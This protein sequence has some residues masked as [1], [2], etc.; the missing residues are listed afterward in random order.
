MPVDSFVEF[1]EVT[2]T[3]EEAPERPS[4]R[5]EQ[6]KKNL[7]KRMS[8]S[9]GKWDTNHPR[10]RLLEALF[11]FSRYKPRQMAE[12]DRYKGLY[13]HV[14]KAQKAVRPRPSRAFVSYFVLL[15]LKKL[16]LAP[17]PQ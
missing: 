5:H 15:S 14:S 9:H 3:I 16:S 8:K 4:P 12:L 10:H 7:L 6:E 11:G 13:K 2:V 17:F 1:H